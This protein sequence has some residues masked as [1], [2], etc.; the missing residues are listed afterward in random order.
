MTDDAH[1]LEPPFIASAIHTCIVTPDLRAAV[2]D[3]LRLGIG[4]FDLYHIDTATNSRAVYKGKPAKF[5]YD[6]AFTPD[7]RWEVTQPAGGVSIFSDFLAETGGR[8]GY[9][10]MAVQP[11]VDYDRALELLVER[12]FELVLSMTHWEKVRVSYFS[13]GAGVH[14]V[15]TKPPGF[16]PPPPDEK[17]PRTAERSHPAAPASGWPR[18]DG[19]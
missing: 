4:P 11:T 12:G 17:I 3:Y 19:K 1:R 5:R 6:V 2:D 18:F 10:H 14:E 13:R 8:A 7:H 9:Q 16:K 15:F